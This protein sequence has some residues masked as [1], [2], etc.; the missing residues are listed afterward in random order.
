MQLV[1]QGKINLCARVREYLPKFKIADEE[2][3]ENL[4]VRHLLTHM[5][6][7]DGD[8][9]PETGMGDDALGR[10]TALL[11]DREQ[12][13]PLGTVWSYNNV[14]FVVLGEIME[15]VAGNPFERIIQ[16]RVFDPLR[17]KHS[18]MR[19]TDVMTQRFATGH[20]VRSEGPRTVS[21]WGMTRDEPVPT[22][23]LPVAR[24][25]C[26]S[27]RGSTLGTVRRSTASGSSTKSPW[28]NSIRLW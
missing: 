25:T 11:A 10:C 15:R 27:T 7:W 2:T 14:G 21:Q 17:M 22:A 16:E 5:A 28:P 19:A 13:A 6:G 26:L 18:F 9:W 24:G 12:I 23:E 1:E 20:N 4:T 8:F 3:A